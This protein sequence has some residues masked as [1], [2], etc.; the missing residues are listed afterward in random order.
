LQAWG[1]Q[2]KLSHVNVVAFSGRQRKSRFRARRRAP[3]LHY[4]SQGFEMLAFVFGLCRWSA[5][6][7]VV[8]TELHE[9]PL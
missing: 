7:L 1:S 6:L 8:I 9:F 4:P 3:P 5:N 2:I